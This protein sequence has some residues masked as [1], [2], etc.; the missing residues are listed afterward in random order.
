M[1][2]HQFVYKIVSYTRNSI[3]FSYI[4]QYKSIFYLAL[5][6]SYNKLVESKKCEIGQEEGLLVYIEENIKFRV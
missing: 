1:D 6:L 3:K 2:Y 4:T 5:S